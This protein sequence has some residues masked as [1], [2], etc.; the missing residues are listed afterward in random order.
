MWPWF[1]RSHGNVQSILIN[2][3]ASYVLKEW[4]VMNL[5]SENIS[6]SFKIYCFA[7]SDSISLYTREFCDRL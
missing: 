3:T 5:F 6:G 4:L 2:L 7:E 1:T